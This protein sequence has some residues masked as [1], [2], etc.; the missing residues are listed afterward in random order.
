MRFSIR[1]LFLLTV[2]V[3]MAVGW[4]LQAARHSALQSEYKSLRKRF[5]TAKTLV[6]GNAQLTIEEAG[7]GIC[8]TMPQGWPQTL[9]DEWQ[10]IPA[11]SPAPPP[12]VEYPVA[13]RR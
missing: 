13:R 7:D 1:D 9:V 4:S 6:Q 8:V 2:I 12:G 11:P 10:P 5:D 3:A